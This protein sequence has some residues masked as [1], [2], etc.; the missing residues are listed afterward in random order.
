MK[1]ADD[2]SLNLN[3]KMMANKI[4]SKK[5]I[6]L[7]IDNRINQ[8]KVENKSLYNLELDLINQ[9]LQFEKK[10]GEL[11]QNKNSIVSN[12]TKTRDQIPIICNKI[13]S[14]RF[15]INKIITNNEKKNIA[16]NRILF[17]I[18]NL[19]QNLSEILDI[20]ESFF[21]L[22]HNFHSTENPLRCLFTKNNNSTNR[23]MPILLSDLKTLMES[24][25]QSLSSSNVYFK[26]SIAQLLYSNAIEKE[27]FL[28]L[29]SSAKDSVKT[30][31]FSQLRGIDN[32]DQI[33]E[34]PILCDME[35]VFEDLILICE[36]GLNNDPKGKMK[37]IDESFRIIQK[38]LFNT[39]IYCTQENESLEKKS[40]SKKINLKILSKQVEN[41]VK[42]MISCNLKRR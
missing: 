33:S 25:A 9:I 21:S 11:A 28:N 23:E 14:F 15:I 13:E 26:S 17:Q 35:K 42:K 36:Q 20:R 6:S 34:N 16:L 18:K 24:K 31:S 38:I 30:V 3:L 37:E 1:A 4:N 19:N 32:L 39:Q 8:F 22:N 10:V 40:K 2:F 7:E 5:R 27:T 29:F 41:Q 12:I